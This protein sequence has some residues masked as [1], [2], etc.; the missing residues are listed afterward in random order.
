MNANEADIAALQ[1]QQE[2]KKIE[3]E[4]QFITALNQLKTQYQ[5]QIQMIREEYVMTLRQ[6]R[7]LVDHEQRIVDQQIQR[8]NI[9]IKEEHE[10]MLAQYHEMVSRIQKMLSLELSPQ[11]AKLDELLSKSVDLGS[12]KNIIPLKQRAS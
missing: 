2:Q 5:Q 6:K 12:Q 9:R 10:R 11:F 4:R 7:K 1:H 8:M 3:M